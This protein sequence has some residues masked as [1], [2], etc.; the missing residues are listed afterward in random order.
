MCRFY[1]YLYEHHLTDS[2][3]DSGAVK[4]IE[5][6]VENECPKDGYRVC[7]IYPLMWELTIENIRQQ[8]TDFVTEDLK[9][10]GTFIPS[11]F[12]KEVSL[13]PTEKMPFRLNGRID[14]ID[15]DDTNHTFRIV[16]YK[17][18]KKDHETK[19]LVSDLF[20]YLTFQPFLYL[21][22]ALYLEDLKKYTP[23]ES[24]LLAINPKYNKRTLTHEQFETISTQACTFFNY[25]TD[26]IKNGTFFIYQS[27][28]KTDNICKYCPYSS[29]CRKDS[30]NTLLR[31]RKSA[32]SKKH[33]EER[34]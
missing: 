4:Y 26:L 16:D 5:Q 12:E 13:E 29:I 23:A 22:I 31:A 18:S 25:L 14:R 34:K 2:L 27:D 10:L 21:F 28:K 8:L 11:R 3:F 9:E 15:L 30:F 32:L 1:S 19:N 17:S 24:V 6:I 7:G 33:K 20:R